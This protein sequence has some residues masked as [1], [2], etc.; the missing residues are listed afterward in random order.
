MRDTDCN[1]SDHD[2][3]AYPLKNEETINRRAWVD[4]ALECVRRRLEAGEEI[5]PAPEKSERPNLY[6]VSSGRPR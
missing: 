2:D 5:G 1:M 3:Q 6:I 4:R